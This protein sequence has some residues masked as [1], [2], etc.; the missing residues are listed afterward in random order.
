MKQ[1][2][3][4]LGILFLLI[5]ILVALGSTGSYM[6][7][8]LY[9]PNATAQEPSIF[10]IRP[11][12]G[13]R[14]VADNL[15]A[16]AYIPSSVAFELYARFRGY[17]ERLQ[18]GRYLISD[19]MSSVQ[20]LEKIVSGDAVFDEVTITIPE[21]WSLA[22]I[23]VYFEDL[24]LFSK[25]EFAEA[26]VMQ[27]AYEDFWFLD[28]LEEDTILDGYLFPDTYRIFSDSTPVSIVRRMLA[29]FGA[30]LTPEMLETLEDQ[31][32]TLREL[33]ILASIVQK[34]APEGDMEEIAGVFWNRLRDGWH[35][36]S[37]ATVNYVLGTSKLQPT[38]ADT[39]VD[40]PYNTYR[41]PGLPPGP[42]GN[43]GMEAI[44]A[45]LN[46]VEHDYY[47]FLHKPTRETVFSRT[48]GE[49]LAAKRRYL[50]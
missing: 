9:I 17:E 29:N 41:Y 46:P 14:Q 15:Q 47:F 32:R 50:D 5:V 35:L 34:E 24:G 30:R 2:A 8:S 6:Y 27:D 44:L 43:P 7:R 37:D 3:R 16:Q 10:E 1:K 36:E 20:I 31:D 40:D 45:S 28:P 38:F 33:L 25:E 23:E 26:A 49:H 19:R 18:A 42:I 48:F 4:F 21:G 12:Q 39:E 11:G 13:L 22:D